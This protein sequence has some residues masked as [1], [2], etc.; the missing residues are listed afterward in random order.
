MINQF[1]MLSVIFP[2]IKNKPIC[3]SF[4]KKLTENTLIKEIID[5]NGNN[6]N[7]I[8]TNELLVKLKATIHDKTKNDYKYNCNQC[9]YETISHSWQCP[10]CKSW[11][12]SEPINFLEK[13]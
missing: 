11:E 8:L 3:E 12:T 1:S 2:E 7:D 6:S 10:T 9:G 4:K 13:I 5:L